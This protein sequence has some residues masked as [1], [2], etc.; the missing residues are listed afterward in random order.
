MLRHVRAATT[1]LCDLTTL[2]LPQRFDVVLLGSHLINAPD[3]GERRRLFAVCKEH[4]HPGGVVLIE[5]YP[6]LGGW[7][8]CAFDYTRAGR[9]AST[10]SSRRARAQI[11]FQN[12]HAGE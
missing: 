3:R 12:A 9:G 8:T 4:A 11:C 10:R 2:Q 1:V 5:R 7:S 6:V